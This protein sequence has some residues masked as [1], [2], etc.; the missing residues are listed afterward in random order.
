MK[1]RL[2]GLDMP[3]DPQRYPK[4]LLGSALVVFLVFLLAILLFDYHLTDADIPGS[5][6]ATPLLAYWL[7]VLFD[8]Q[9]SHE[10]E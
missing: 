2:F 10:S 8:G 6:L 4:F 1:F 3:F 9:A 7:H 5:L